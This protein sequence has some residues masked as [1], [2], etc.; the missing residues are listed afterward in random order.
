MGDQKRIA[1]KLVDLVICEVSGI[2]LRNNLLHKCW[3]YRVNQQQSI[4]ID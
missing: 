4:L 2:P 1:A 3:V